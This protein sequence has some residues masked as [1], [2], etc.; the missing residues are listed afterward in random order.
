MPCCGQ[1]RQEM[2]LQSPNRIPNERTM[3]SP[4]QSPVCEMEYIGGSTLTVLGPVSGKTYRFV[5]YGA[6]VPIDI[7]DRRSIVNVPNLRE[8]RR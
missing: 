1:K 5:G 2:K 4:P 7:R 8:R 3:A 6:K